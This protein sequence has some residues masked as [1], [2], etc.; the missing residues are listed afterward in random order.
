MTGARFVLHWLFVLGLGVPVVVFG[1]AQTDKAGLPEKAAPSVS[2]AAVSP[3]PRWAELSSVQKG[4]LSPLAGAWDTLSDGH[5]R[6]WIALAQNYNSLTPAEQTTL[7]SRM[8]DWAA[9]NPKEREQARLNFAQTKKT[10]PSDRTA[11]WEA[12]QALSPEDREKLAS[13][14][15]AKDKPAGAAIVVKPVAP[16]KM[17]AVPPPKKAQDSKQLLVGNGQQLNRNTLLPLP[18]V[19]PAPPEANPEGADAGAGAPTMP[20]FPRDTSCAMQDSPSIPG[21]WR[22]MACWVYE[23]ILMFGVVFISGYLFGTLSQTRNAMDNRHAL[24]AFLFVVF[25]IYFVWFWA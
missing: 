12:Y 14:A 7:H 16:E 24:Q 11:N 2:T 15:K 5:R 25:G 13:K 18:S 3:A 23:G 20:A 21:L 19:A 8:A 10:A 22:R 9:L 17:V 4:A 6:K 1:Q